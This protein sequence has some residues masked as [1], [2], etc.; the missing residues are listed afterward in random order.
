MSAP[1]VTELVL[2]AKPGR[3]LVRAE[4]GGTH[5]QI[6]RRL[7]AV[8]LEGPG[9][10]PLE[11]RD[12]VDRLAALKLLEGRRLPAMAPIH[13]VRLRGATLEI[14]EGWVD[15]FPLADPAATESMTVP[16]ALGIVHDLARGL[17]VL[18]RT[19]ES[20]GRPA[21]L[22]HG[23]V[24]PSRL[25]IDAAGQVRLVGNEGLRGAPAA[26][27]AGLMAALQALLEVCT[28]TSEGRQLL[29]RVRA[30]SF[31]STE[32][33]EAA[34]QNYL[35][36][37]DPAELAARRH[38][39]NATVREA[40]GLGPGRTE[41]E[42]GAFETPLRSSATSSALDPSAG[43]A[44]PIDD[45][46]TPVDP[47]GQIATVLEAF[48]ELEA[49]EATLDASEDVVPPPRAAGAPLPRRASS[50]SRGG[51]NREGVGRYRLVASIGRGGMGAIYLAR[52]WDGGQ[53]GPL[54]ALKILGSTTQDPDFA[55]AVAMLMDEAAIM[56]RID[57]P[58]VL[59]VL[60]FGRSQGRYFLATEYLEGR[61]LVRLM[62]EAYAQERGLDY[63]VVATIG[64]DAALGL[65]AA[66]TASTVD[67]APLK[68]I[69]RDVSPQ[70][71]F[72]TY[73]G[74]TK[75]I[76]FGVARASERVS[77]TQ[78]G[79]V[80]GKTAYMSPEQAEGRA[81][82]GRSDV[83]SLGV[84]LWEMTAG[85]R[86]F[87][88]DKEY[89]TLVAVR[90]ADIPP[91]TQVRGR[92]NPVLDHIILS[93]LHRDPDVRTPSAHALATQLLELADHESG[94]DRRRRVREL[95]HRLF[96]D[97]A[98]KERELIE[99]LEA[100]AS[101]SIESN[102]L[103]GVSGVSADGD[104]R[105]ITLVGR[106]AGL[107]EL[108]GFGSGRWLADRP[109]TAEHVIRMV[110]EARLD[111]GLVPP[112]ANKDGRV[113]APG[114]KEDS[115]WTPVECVDR[116]A[117]DEDATIELP[118]EWRD[119]GFTLLP[120]ADGGPWLEDPAGDGFVAIGPQPAAEP[121]APAARPS[122]TPRPSR[123]S[124]PGWVMG[125]VGA[126]FLTAGVWLGLFVNG[127]IAGLRGSP[128]SSGP[129][130][131]PPLAP[132]V[133]SLRRHGVQVVQARN[134][135]VVSDDEGATVILEPEGRFYPVDVP[136]AKGWLIEASGGAPVA[137]WVGAVSG[138]AW[139]VRSL[140]VNDCP[141]TVRA[142]ADG[143]VVRYGDEAVRLPHGGGVLLDVAV[144]RPDFADRLE[145]TTLGLS[146]GRRNER[147]PH[148]HCRAGWGDDRIVLRR[149]PPGRYALRW[150][151]SEQSHVVTL[152][153]TASSADGARVI[154]AARRP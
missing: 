83:F 63:G 93:A 12:L 78:V 148:R 6:I 147:R 21:H 150:T 37:Q 15:G 81:L 20:D 51:L 9:A 152:N 108:E 35:A 139:F 115:P 60:D 13:R 116:G 97:V 65:Y 24:K 73:D 19:P 126:L 84:C 32:S 82:G 125:F 46:A 47:G 110:T 85:R 69:H 54:V 102:E 38:R 11:E 1:G 17:A 132:F 74:V 88:R 151:G 77:R 117:T 103:A 3:V 107:N 111:L 98:A 53:P 31:P 113:P 68:V 109:S 58:H 130:R 100:D 43:W 79:L 128:P 48:G 99:R 127:P 59:K 49:E 7:N 66:H 89:E 105:Q 75:V 40:L 94:P 146:F 153:L 123:R 124:F 122:S 4:R 129:S 23:R 28:T 135:L 96:G 112:P 67:G 87:K 64:A 29:Q 95:L 5:P 16:V 56:A 30:L 10:A 61:P 25:M 133:A 42:S 120:D 119:R 138:S 33:I 91:P 36:R 41:T 145:V 92:P 44:A 26:D 80:K 2:S 27:A 114:P 70:N 55:D 134:G 8:L 14:T 18:H 131:R 154:R 50:P 106:P 141:A 149:L 144:E 39:F 136:A 143:V 101:G 86:L 45:S 52:K 90:T 140:S 57:H 137:W 71:V 118:Q 62:V 72:V 121:G 76:D 104:V 22:I 34:L 142:D